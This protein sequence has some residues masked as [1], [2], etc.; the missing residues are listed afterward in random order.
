MS[1]CHD[2]LHI[3]L[4]KTEKKPQWS[5][6]FLLIPMHW[7]WPSI[8]QIT[9]NL[10]PYLP[11]SSPSCPRGWAPC[12]TAAAACHRPPSSAGTGP[13][14]HK[15]TGRPSKPCCGGDRSAQAV[16]NTASIP[17]HVKQRQTTENWG[18]IQYTLYRFFPPL[19]QHREYVV[20]FK[21]NVSDI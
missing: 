21:N 6:G 11:C 9:A 1:Q 13:S 8:S 2:F 16:L 5:W 18:L 10:S 3:Q 4:Y 12:Q 15:V 20:L 17:G 19:W 14:P 7:I